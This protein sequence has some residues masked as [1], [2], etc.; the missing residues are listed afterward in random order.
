MKQKLIW[1]I[2]FDFHANKTDLESILNYLHILVCDLL[3][4]IIGGY[5]KN[6]VQKKQY[7][8]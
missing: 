6:S 7:L 8:G 4:T 3:T 2:V 5:A 1:R